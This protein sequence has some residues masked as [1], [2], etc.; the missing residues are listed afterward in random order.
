[1]PLENRGQ[2][3]MG[4]HWEKTVLE[5]EFMTAEVV[6]NDGIYSNFTFAMFEDSG[7]YK[8]TYKNVDEALWG[9][10]KGCD[11]LTSCDPKKFIEFDGKDSVQFCTFDHTA[12]ATLPYWDPY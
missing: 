2:G 11:F 5:N 6:Y 1:M 7:W 4:S 12:V 8:P 10:D 9:K 3:I